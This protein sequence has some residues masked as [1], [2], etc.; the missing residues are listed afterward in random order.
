MT[1]ENRLTSFRGFIFAESLI[2]IIITPSPNIG[3]GPPLF[4]TLRHGRTFYRDRDPD[5]LIY[6]RN[7]PDVLLYTGGG[8]RRT[9]LFDG[10]PRPLFTVRRTGRYNLFFL[11]S[12]CLAGP[13]PMILVSFPAPLGPLAGLVIMPI[14]ISHC[15]HGPG[16]VL[17]LWII[18]GLPLLTVWMKAGVH[19]ITEEATA[20]IRSLQDQFVATPGRDH[21]PVST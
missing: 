11:S 1:S 21:R 19:R 18:M 17:R 10:Y 15:Y 16:Q 9:I 12:P 20:F 7:R 5:M 3:R 2:P 6:N 13:S 4:C 14:N 8:H